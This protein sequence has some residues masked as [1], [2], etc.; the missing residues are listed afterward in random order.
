ML[1]IHRHWHVTEQDHTA[2][3]LVEMLDGRSWTLCTG[4][5]C[6]AVL[7]LCDATSPD[8]VQEYAIVR[9]SDLV[10]VETVTVSWCTREQLRRFAASFSADPCSGFIMERLRHEQISSAHEPCVHCR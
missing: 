9:E 5:R 3:E 10:Q 2:D 6:G 4:F 7:W 8:A 1:H